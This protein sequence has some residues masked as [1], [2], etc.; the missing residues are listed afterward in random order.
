MSSEDRKERDERHHE[1]GKMDGESGGD[2]NPP[3]EQDVGSELLFGYSK[4]ELQD[5]EAYDHGHGSTKR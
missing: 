2:K 3:H 4:D 1:L 5:R